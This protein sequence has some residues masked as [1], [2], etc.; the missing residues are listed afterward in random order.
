[1]N[2][3][4]SV[5]NYSVKQTKTDVADKKIE[6]AKKILE[7]FSVGSIK[8]SFLEFCKRNA[9]NK[10]KEINIEVLENFHLQYTLNLILKVFKT[11]N[12]K[13]LQLVMKMRLVN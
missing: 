6:E 10:Q 7:N 4:R 12:Y 11:A 3:C 9:T 5:I 8:V 1:M 2:S 13:R